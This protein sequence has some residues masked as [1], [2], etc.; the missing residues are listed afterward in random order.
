MISGCEGDSK[1]NSSNADAVIHT[2]PYKVLNVEPY[3]TGKKAQVKAFAY[4][5]SDTAT[6]ENL[7]ATLLE[8]YSSLKSYNDFRNFNAPTVIA[9]Y[10]YTSKEKANNMKESWIAMLSKTP[11]ADEP[12]IS[13]DNMKHEALLN[14]KDSVRSEDELKFGAMDSI[15]RQ[16]NTDL[17]T[18]Y[19]TLYEL[20]GEGIKQAD[21]KYPDFGEEHARYST[22]WYRNEKAKVFKKYK[23][24]DSLSTYITILGIS[25]CK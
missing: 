21:K 2:L 22:T 12:Q 11:A 24:H 23:I 8:I 17:C 3:E 16:R 15:L 4:L 1:E 5:E 25:Y 19:R 10:L 7:E 14:L 20:E 9:V 13:I 18:I 6:K